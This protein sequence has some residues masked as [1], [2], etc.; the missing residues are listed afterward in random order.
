LNPVG[1]IVE[2]ASWII[3]GLVTGSMA[4]LAM[5]G[6]AAGG[7]P[8]AI[9]IGL[10]GAIIGGFLGKTI[11]ADAAASF[12]LY[13]S[14]MA[15]IGAMDLL[16]IY[17]C[18][19]MRF[20]ANQ[21]GSRSASLLRANSAPQEMDSDK[22]IR[23]TFDRY[24]MDNLEDYYRRN[25]CIREQQY[26]SQDKLLHLAAFCVS[27]VAIATDN[28]G[29]ARQDEKKVGAAL[30]AIRQLSLLCEKADQ[31]EQP[32]KAVIIIDGQSNSDDKNK[33]PHTR[34]PISATLC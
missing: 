27:K 26:L 25:E 17:R 30:D 5:P 12:N 4:R 24:Y 20:E 2:I 16:F 28:G 21:I 33:P 6:P 23:V 13:A 8:V 9:L 34:L 14:F 11:A 10:V 7:M 29:D 31:A 3:V 15:A 18:V 1:V 22:K 19:A 32:V